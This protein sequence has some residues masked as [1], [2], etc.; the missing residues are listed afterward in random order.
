MQI[1]VTIWMGGVALYWGWLMS[2]GT[3]LTLNW[4]DR[5]KEIRA[6]AFLWPITVGIALYY[7]AKDRRQA[8]KN[9]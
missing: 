9:G 2:P 7:I 6:A 5:D 1:A 4:R 8:R 3:K